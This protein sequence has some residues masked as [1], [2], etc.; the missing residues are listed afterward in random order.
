MTKPCLPPRRQFLKAATVL[1]FSLAGKAFAVAAPKT[2]TV[3]TSYPDEFTSRIEA[4]FEKAHPEYRLRIIWRMPNDASPFLL[5][6]GHG[7]ADVYWSASARSFARLAREGIWRKLPIDRSKLPDHIGKAALADRDGYYT[8]TEVAGYGFAV[9]PPMLAARGLPPPADWNDLADPRL[10]GLVA[11]P[12]PARVGFAPAMVEVVLQSYGWKRGWALWGEIAANA[13]LVDRGSTFVTDEVASGRCAVGL[14]IDF[15]VN[16]AIAN[17]TP[18]S[19]IYPSHTGINPAHIAVTRDCPN[20]PGAEAFVSFMLS[21]PGQK[22]LGHPDIRRLP[23][24]PDVYAELPQHYFNPFAAAKAGNLQFDSEAARPRLATTAGIFQQMLIEP[25]DEL[26][27]LWQR[28]HQAESGGRPMTKVRELLGTPPIDEAAANEVA[29]HRQ[30][31]Q[32]LEGEAPGTPSDPEHA[33]MA[34]CRAQRDAARR[35]LSE[36]G[37]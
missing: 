24:R 20:P 31:G 28:V 19:F 6:A 33:W 5:Q 3:V 26:K 29:L 9:S 18:L 34:S 35:L 17:G 4:A 25:H 2:V 32:R 21:E 22:I 27:S 13:V 1:G 10:A 36:D 23:V 16:S 15:F 8:A 7:G 14:S 30:L 37:A 12:I 11:L